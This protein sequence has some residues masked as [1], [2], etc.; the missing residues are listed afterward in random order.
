M[1][2]Q[3]I[4]YKI[5]SAAWDQILWLENNGMHFSRDANGKLAKRTFGGHTVHFGE[6][7]AYRA[8]F[9]AD[10]TG[11]GIMDTCW[12]ESLKRGISFITQSIA[13]ELLFSRS[14][15]IGCIVY[16][17]KQGELLILVF[18]CDTKLCQHLLQPNKFGQ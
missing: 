1:A 11:K 2:D 15:C 3:N 8:V 12:G 9:E 14:Q 16:K 5:C 17:Q 6:S 18:M 7:S 10:R 4:I 13:T